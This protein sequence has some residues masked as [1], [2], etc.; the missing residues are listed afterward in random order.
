MYARTVMKSVAPTVLV[1]MLAALYLPQ[2]GFARRLAANTINPTATL[3]DHGS[4]I[5][6]TGPLL[7]TQ[8][9]HVKLRVTVTQRTTGAI[10]EGHIRFTGTT[11]TQ[12][13]EVEAE[14]QGDERFEPG[15][16]TAVAVA[17]S[18]VQG[19]ATDAHQWLV[20]ITLSE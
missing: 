1:V 11:T 3:K 9:E 7:C 19:D 14:A 13:W 5:V 18:S 12:Q 15:P 10:A 2:L 8:T 20:N 6:V 17:I 4:R 16:A